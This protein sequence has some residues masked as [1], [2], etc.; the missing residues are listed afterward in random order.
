[1]PP[2][3]RL[4][5]RFSKKYPQPLTADQLAPLGSRLVVGSG[6][7]RIGR[8]PQFQVFPAKRVSDATAASAVESP[9]VD[10]EILDAEMVGRLTVV[11]RIYLESIQIVQR[12][13]EGELP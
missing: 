6:N 1:V 9:P 2:N 10:R 5:V 13:N 7:P 11:A 4:Q 8:Q 12:K 3:L